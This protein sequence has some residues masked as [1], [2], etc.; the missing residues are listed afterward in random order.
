MPFGQQIGEGALVGRLDVQE[1]GQT[2][3]CNVRGGGVLVHCDLRLLHP[4]TQIPVLLEKS[5]VQ[6]VS[7]GFTVVAQVGQERDN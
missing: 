7:A 5:A 2:A 4:Y 6:Q 3:G 1:A